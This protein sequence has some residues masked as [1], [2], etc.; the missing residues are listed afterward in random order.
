MC[1]HAKSQKNAPIPART[2]M[3]S[4]L[5]PDKCAQPSEARRCS[6][7]EG[8][9]ACGI[10]RPFTPFELVVGWGVSSTEGSLEIWLDGAKVVCTVG[11]LEGFELSSLDGWLDCLGDGWAVGSSFDTVSSDNPPV[12]SFVGG[13]E[14]S[15]EVTAVV[16]TI[17]E[18]VG[19]PLDFELGAE[20]GVGF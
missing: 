13:G 6:A 2:V 5:S 10:I 12:G 7:G 9:F 3:V 16:L 17:G 19:L 18:I 14:D 11:W 20:D 15:D 8:I 1:I 4:I